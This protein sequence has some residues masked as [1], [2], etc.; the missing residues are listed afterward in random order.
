MLAA[1]RKRLGEIL[2][3]FYWRIR[4]QGDALHCPVCDRGFARFRDMHASYSL[5]GATVNHD[6]ANCYCPACGSNIRHRLLAQAY[7][8]W[9]AQL[10]T[11]PRL[12]HFAPEP[13]LAAFFRGRGVDY[14]AADLEAQP[15]TTTRKLDMT[16]I[17]L[18]DQSFDAVIAVHVLEHIE[19]DRAA[20]SELHRILRPGGMAFIQVPTYGDLTYEDP[21]LDAAGRERMFGIAGHVRMYGTDIASRLDAAGFSTVTLS[22]DDVAGNYIDRSVRSPHVDSSRYVFVCRKA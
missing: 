11:R 8:A 7:P 4:Y 22:L 12:L 19:R 3:L 2:G 13:G 21:T 10:P 5:R 17:D 16:A 6:T 9:S 18:P 1:A 20:M 15:G 14:V